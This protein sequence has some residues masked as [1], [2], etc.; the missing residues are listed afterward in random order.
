MNQSQLKYGETALRIGEQ[1]LQC[2]NTID[3]NSALF[4]EIQSF[5]IS[6]DQFDNFYT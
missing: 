1:L 6:A 5:K 3:E 4:K 2:E